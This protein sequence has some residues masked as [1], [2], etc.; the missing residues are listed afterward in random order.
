MV[1]T[2]VSL[3]G[4]SGSTLD[5]KPGHFCC[6]EFNPGLRQGCQVF[7]MKIRLATIDWTKRQ[8]EERRTGLQIDQPGVHCTRRYSLCG[9]R[10]K[11]RLCLAASMNIDRTSPQGGASWFGHIPQYQA[12]YIL[13]IASIRL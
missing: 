3:S 6:H 2:E 8:D 1:S 7:R 13:V 4:A 12:I 5:Y 11:L 10:K 9:E